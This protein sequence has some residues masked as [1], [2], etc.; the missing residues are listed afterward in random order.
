MSCEVIRTPRGGKIFVCARG[1]R[2]QICALCKQREAHYLCDHPVGT[3]RKAKTCDRPLCETCAV[4][5]GPNTHKCFVH[6]DTQPELPLFTR[7]QSR[8][9]FGERK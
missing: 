6:P 8:L 9:L 2:K 1:E 4:E 7:E 3:K 5:T